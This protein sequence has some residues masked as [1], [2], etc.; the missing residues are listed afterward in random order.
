[1]V[2]VAGGITP[3]A[4]LRDA[5]LIRAKFR[6]LEDP[7]LARLRA[8]QAVGGLADM[9]PEERAYLK[10]KGREER[11]RAVVDFQRLFEEG[12]ESQDILL[13]GGDVI[14]IPQ[15][16]RTVSL[17]GQLRNPGLIHYEEGQRAEWYIQEAGGYAFN[18]HKRGARLIRARSGQREDL[19]ANLTIKPGDEIW[20]PEKQYR[21]WWGFVQDTVRTTAEALTLLV[22]IRTL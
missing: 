6:T 22:L 20:V 17:S 14:F 19:H 4:S 18:A 10:T 16:R 13:E 7:E 12:D 21:D 8:V 9:S 3:N 2:A 11:G 1:L 15:T 5:R